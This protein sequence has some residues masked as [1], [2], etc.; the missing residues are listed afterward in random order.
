MA[1][2]RDDVEKRCRLVLVTP[3][4]ADPGVVSAQL[5]AAGRGGDIACVIVP[6]GALGEDAFQ[7]SLEGLVPVGQ[8]FGAA[9]IVAGDPRLAARTGA[10][11]IHVR[12]DAACLA[13][14]VAD[15]Q[16]RFVVGAEA[17]GGRHRALEAG[18]ER[19][20][21]VLFG[22]LGGDTHP[23]AHPGA[24]ESAAWWAEFV[25]LPAI[26]MGGRDLAHLDAAAAT[27]VDFVA[28]SHAV[29]G[30]DGDPEAAV[31]AANAILARHVL[32]AAA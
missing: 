31:R 14:A 25:E 4:D 27:G 30:P 2:D 23:G 28:L 19:P 32:A 9:M 29:F 15:H 5:A 17:G 12:G 24:A 13:R 6:G 1:N 26:L 21:Y 10:D 3:A 16:G 20:D 18:E 22:R 7:R 8:A 11:G